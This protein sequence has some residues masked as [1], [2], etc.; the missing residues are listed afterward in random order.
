MIPVTVPTLL[1]HPALPLLAAASGDGTWFDRK[2][3]QQKLVEAILETLGMTFVSGALAIVFG[4]LLGLALVT[5]GSRGQHRNRFLYEAL[6]QV[7]NFGRSMPF[8]ILLVAIIAFTRLVVGT[9]IGWQAA[10]VPLTVGAIPFYARLVEN[11]IA[12]VDEGKVEAALMMG[13]T[14]TQ[15]TWG[16]LV[17]EALP[18]LISAGTVTFITLLGYSAMAGT[19]GG[20]GLGDLAIQYGHNRNWTDVIIITV[21]IIAVI[22]AVIQVAGDLLARLVDHRRR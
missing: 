1:A 4:L 21:V 6:S 16:V 5:T 3:I 19:V 17:R 8:I 20:G 15:I 10:C 13:A 22:V 11:A 2:V 9:S 7:V 14:P 12:E 18:G